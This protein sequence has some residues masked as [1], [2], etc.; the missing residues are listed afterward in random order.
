MY[1]SRVHEYS[2]PTLTVFDTSMP[3]LILGKLQE[4]GAPLNFCSSR[5]STFFLAWRKLLIHIALSSSAKRLILRLQP[6]T[7]SP[8][9]YPHSLV[10]EF[11]EV[12]LKMP[13]IDDG[14][15]A[16]LEPFYNGKKLTDPISTKEDKFQ[17]LPAF[18]KVKGEALALVNSCFAS[19]AN[20]SKVL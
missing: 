1:I 18:L 17:L 13:L 4:A 2:V 5:G 20:M 6:L 16:L 19:K 11:L 15:E 8:H 14:F 3:Y 7:N 9:L 10:H 12:T